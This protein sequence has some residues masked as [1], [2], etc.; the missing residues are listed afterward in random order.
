LNVGCGK[1]HSPF[2]VRGSP[3][4]VPIGMVTDVR[5]E[6]EEALFVELVELDFWDTGDVAETERSP[7]CVVGVVEVVQFL[8]FLASLR[9]F[10]NKLLRAAAFS[11]VESP[12]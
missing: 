5:A 12:A 9:L 4:A 11:S 8:Y 10:R 6:Q 1:R 3:V 7:D 2:V